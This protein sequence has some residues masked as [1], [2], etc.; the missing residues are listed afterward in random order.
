MTFILNE[1]LTSARNRAH[2]RCGNTPTEQGRCSEPAL[3]MIIR[4]TEAAQNV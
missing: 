4:K 2:S 1:Y 3:G